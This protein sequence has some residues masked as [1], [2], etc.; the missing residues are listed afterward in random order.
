MSSDLSGRV[1][2]TLMQ[3]LSYGAFKSDESFTVREDEGLLEAS[4]TQNEPDVPVEYGSNN[5]YFKLIGFM[6]SAFLLS[7]LLVAVNISR[8]S[9][10]EMSGNFFI[11]SSDASTLAVTS[12][13]N[14]YGI[15]DS[16]VML[17]Y[18][19][20]TNALLAEPY[21]ESIIILADT[22]NDCTYGWSMIKINDNSTTYDGV[23]TDGTIVFT[24]NTVGEYTFT[25]LESCSDISSSS[26]Q[27]SMSVWVKY[28]RRELSTLNDIDREDFLDAFY[29]LW[30]VSTADGII[31]YGDKY[32]SV[33]YFATLH[34]DGGGNPVCDEFH[35][36]LGF[37][38]N[39]MYLS[40]YLEQS[41]Q[42]VNP[43]VALHYLEYTK[44]FE[45]S[46]YQKRKYFSTKHLILTK[47]FRPNLFY[48]FYNSL[49]LSNQLDGGSWTEILT[50][51]YFGSSD[52]ETG[53]IT[54]GRWANVAVPYVTH[55]F[56]VEE[57]IDPDVTFFKADEVAW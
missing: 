42:L 33:N 7:S 46:S 10:G 52:P 41:L 47:S 3:F 4:Y 48:P 44:Y 29:T 20:L 17:P 18:P 11:M 55:D 28:V 6:A 13:S 39:H 43:K 51:K 57:G 35:G 38:N 30:T 21:K 19:F 9:P 36:G 15:W 16:S 54:D 31:M 45:N 50:S 32:K 25:V 14:E 2:T 5:F 8:P 49:D 56:L 1:K 53:R 34:N 26:R 24:L 12:I 37:L 27:L 23:S 22:I 40:A